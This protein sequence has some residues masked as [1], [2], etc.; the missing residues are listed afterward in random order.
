ME[1]TSFPGDAAERQRSERW[2][3]VRLRWTQRSELA[4]AAIDA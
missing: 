3:I 4:S 2:A 1:E